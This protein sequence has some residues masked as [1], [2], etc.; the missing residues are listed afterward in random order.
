MSK[1]DEY[2][3]RMKQQLDDMNAQIG[4][5]EAKSAEAGASMRTTYDEQVKELKKFHA[6]NKEKLE[7]IKGASEGKWDELVSEGEKVH[8]AFVQS[9]NY[10]KSQLK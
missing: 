5:L 4:K 6:S 9:V 2:V 1:R 7:A 10:F 3:E 8:K